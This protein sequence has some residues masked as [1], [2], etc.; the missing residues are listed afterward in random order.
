MAGLR[1][2]GAGVSR[3]GEGYRR[4]DQE[5]RDQRSSYNVLHIHLRDMLRPYLSDN[6]GNAAHCSSLEQG[7]DGPTAM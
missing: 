1:F 4:A 7:K 2:G 6:L 5:E 3:H